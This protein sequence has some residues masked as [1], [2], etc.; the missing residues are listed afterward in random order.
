MPEELDGST[1]N[2][3]YSQYECDLTVNDFTKKSVEK[4]LEFQC[5]SFKTFET[6][7]VRTYCG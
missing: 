7:C 6:S 5:F 4:Q 1:I 2:R 3:L